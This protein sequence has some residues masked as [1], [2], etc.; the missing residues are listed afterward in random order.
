MDLEKEVTEYI[1]YCKVQ[2]HLN[3]HTIKA[4]KIDLKQFLAEIG[5]NYS[6]RDN[7]NGYIIT[8][9]KSYKTKTVRRKI[10][11]LK[12]FIRYLYCNDIIE[13]NPFDKINTRFCEPILL[14]RTIPEHIINNLFREAYANVE[15]ADKN[16]CAL[17]DVS[18]LE[19]LFATGAR[20]SEICGLRIEDVDLETRQV[21]FFGKG[22]KERII[23]IENYDVLH[24][25]KKYKKRFRTDIEGCGYF[26]VN[27]KKQKLSEQSVRA[28]IKK[29]AEQAGS[30]INITPHMFRHSMATMLL[31]EEVDIR[32]IQRILGHSSITT[33]QIYTH[34]TSVKQKEILRSKHPRNKVCI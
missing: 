15:L 18:V 19:M 33:T 26:F 27:N 25:L 21:R 30:A 20:V 7:L 11:T 3:K 28:I 14:P 9:H 13:N 29:I 10:A 24:T 23:N 4:Y 1:E 16:R 12:A 6:L 22:A 2:K 31:E 32:Y 17:R 5:E 8:L 34:V